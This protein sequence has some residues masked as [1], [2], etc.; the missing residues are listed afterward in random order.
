MWV[1]QDN[2]NSRYLEDALYEVIKCATGGGCAYPE[3]PVT[4]ATYAMIARSSMCT[5][6]YSLC[7]CFLMILLKLFLSFANQYDNCKNWLREGSH[8]AGS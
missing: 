1:G 3:H 4:T 5:E 2:F 8:Q 7:C 6:S